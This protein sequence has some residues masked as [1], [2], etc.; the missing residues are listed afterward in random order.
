MQKEKSKKFYINKKI[1][2]LQPGNPLTPK[3]LTQLIESSRN[4]GTISMEDA[5]QKISNSYNKI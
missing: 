3:Q 5:H 2:H 4:S 1:N